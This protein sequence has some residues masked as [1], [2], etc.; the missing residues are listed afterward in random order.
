MKFAFVSQVLPPSWSGQS[1]AIYRVLRDL[2]PSCY[3]LISQDYGEAR[4]HR[5]KK[6]GR[7]RGKY[8]YIPRRHTLTRAWRFAFVRRLIIR[9]R[10]RQIE[11]IIR[12]E[13]CEAVV[14]C[15]GDF[16]DLPAAM[17]ASRATGVAFYPYLLDYYS[18]QSIGFKSEVEAQRLEAEIMKTATGVIVPN[19]FM[20]EE[21]RTRY[22]VRS[23]T[24][25][26]NPCD[27][28]AYEGL[29][30]PEP[31]D[32]FK[33][34]Y[35]GSIYNA[36]FDAFRNLTA[37]LAKLGRPEVRIHLYTNQSREELERN[38]I[39]G[40]VIL[41]GD[42]EPAAIPRIQKG[43]DLLFLPLAFNSPFPELI[44]TSAPGKTGEYLA[45]GRPI[46]VHAPPDSFLAWYFKRH[47]C[48][49]VVDQS[50]PEKLAEAINSVLTDSVQRHKLEANARERALS[51]FSIEASSAAFSRLLGVE[52]TIQSDA[53]PMIA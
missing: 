48:G 21:A 25:V 17:Y 44:R 41:H 9:M 15:P 35:T 12:R 30:A 10:A 34:V 7:L 40:P 24:V 8:F 53:R 42:L 14:A 47:E 45:A 27:V 22:G 36:Q 50:D 2:D 32:D 6:E 33:I 38:G 13:K 52:S 49:L 4:A 11:K 39:S 51:E 3:C 16:F 5:R 26:R 23:V 1:T 31:N 18:Q 37:A 43:A 20:G 29:P 19:E 46:L 28:A